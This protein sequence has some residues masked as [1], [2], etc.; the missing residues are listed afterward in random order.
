MVNELSGIAKKKGTE[1]AEENMRSIHFLGLDC[2]VTIMQSLVDWSAELRESNND[3]LNG[4]QDDDV[5][6]DD[7]VTEIKDSP[8]QSKSKNSQVNF[9]QQKMYASSNMFEIYF[10]TKKLDVVKHW[11]YY[12]TTTS[13]K[14]FLFFGNIEFS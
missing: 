10:K 13:K 12:C 7:L 9:P 4:D 1:S 8:S 14:S 11:Y 5:H 6:V 2:L 3:D